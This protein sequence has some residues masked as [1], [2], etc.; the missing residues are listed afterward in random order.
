MLF[1]VVVVVVVVVVV[2]GMMENHGVELSLPGRKSKQAS[3][4]RWL[5]TFEFSDPRESPQ[6]MPFFFHLLGIMYDKLLWLVFCLAFYFI[7]AKHFIPFSDFLLK[8]VDRKEFHDPISN[9]NKLL[10]VMFVLPWKPIH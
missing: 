10:F 8:F 2:N 3:I 1:F 4:K 7:S 9:E 6:Q 5:T